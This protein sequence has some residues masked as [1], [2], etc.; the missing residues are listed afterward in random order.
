MES[1][2][3]RLIFMALILI[4]FQQRNT[5]LLN[6]A[7]STLKQEDLIM[8]SLNIIMEYYQP[9]NLAVF[10]FIHIKPFAKVMQEWQLRSVFINLVFLI[11]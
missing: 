2:T 10:N 4:N 1:A 9:H 7:P 6:T 5:K 11:H 3:K 8:K